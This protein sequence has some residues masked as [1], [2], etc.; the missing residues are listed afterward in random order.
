MIMSLSLV[1]LA[2]LLSLALLASPFPYLAP[3]V[4][5]GLAGV[6]ALYRKP[7]W[8]LLAIALLVPLEG[9]LKDG[10]VSAAKIVGIG[11]V[12]TLGLQLAVRQLPGER[13]YSNQWRLLVPFLALY[14]LSLWTSDDAALSLNHLREFTVGLVVFVITLL[15]G[16]ELNL[17]ALC[18]VVT[19]SVCV[20]CLFAMFSSKYQQQGRAS[21]L[22]DPNVLAL[23]ITFAMPLALWLLIKA[24]Q[25]P[26]KLFWAVCCLLML[27]GM[28]RTESR[29]GLVVLLAT[30]VAVLYV[31]RAQL[32]RIRPRHLGFAMLGLAIVLPLGAAL[33]PPAY[34]ERIQSLAQ[35]KSGI[36]A[37]KD[38]SLGRRASYLVV[39]KDMISHSPVLGTGPGT[40]PL[41]YAHTGFSKAFAPAKRTS[42]DLYRQAHNTY[43]EL[44]TETGIPAGL[45]F[46]GMMLLALR[47]FTRASASWRTAA[48]HYHA[49]LAAHLTMSLVAIG[50]FLM[51][52]SVPSH[53]YLWMMLALSSVLVRQAAEAPTTAVAR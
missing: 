9:L 18:R 16:R 25:V 19:L 33:M 51:F 1:G 15:V 36:N 26:V 37:H 48:D 27:A 43:L 23:L 3:A 13:L 49:D 34:L 35:L 41:H 5:V 47:N 11:L 7:A 4:V 38:E 10:E 52:L 45:L 42:D 12:L 6:L 50:L 44:F 21:A 8:G 31:Y 14:L 32:A 53:K 30:L 20:T 22:L 40:F 39:G 46:I 17:P 2:A 28:T 29:S 24:R